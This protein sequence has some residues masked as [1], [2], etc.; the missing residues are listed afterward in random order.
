MS[1]C[2]GNIKIKPWSIFIDI[3]GFSKRFQ[4]ESQIQALEILFQLM[5]Y[6]FQIGSRIFPRQP[7]HLFIYQVGDGFLITP[8]KRYE[9]NL[10]RPISI[11][12]ALMQSI[13]LKGGIA[14]ASISTGDFEDYLSEYPQE[15]KKEIE[16][17]DI[18]RIGDGLMTVFQ[19][20]GDAL[21]NSYQL[22]NKAQ[23]GPCLFVDIRLKEYLPK[24]GIVFL[25]DKDRNILIIDWIRSKTKL[26]EKIIKIIYG[27]VPK[28]KN[29]VEAIQNYIK[30]YQELSEEWKKNA[31]SLCF[32]SGLS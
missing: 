19:V 2:N 13:L 3:E 16:K 23:K 27:D 10:E 30:K 20:M 21:I 17:H 15:I 22:A 32:P 26:S 18:V 1:K 5:H 14:R 8:Y 25:E 6:L 31:R 4:E 12:I 11:T 7:E 29:L 28:I 9:E 24:D